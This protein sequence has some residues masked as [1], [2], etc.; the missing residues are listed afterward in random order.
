MVRT[1][2]PRLTLSRPM[3]SSTWGVTAPYL[4]P[5]T[6]AAPKHRPI[7]PAAAS[8]AAVSTANA[9][10]LGCRLKRRDDGVRVVAPLG[11]LIAS[12][13]SGKAV[14]CQ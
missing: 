11:G 6:V 5:S 7:R 14:H 12:Q 8:A 2:C 13:P 9:L 1:I 4:S 10:S 3:S